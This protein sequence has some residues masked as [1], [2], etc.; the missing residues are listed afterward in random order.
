MA[1]KRVKRRRKAIAWG[2]T[3][4]LLVA[5]NLCVGLAISP[6]T[7]LDRVRV[8]G[9]PIADRGRI[10]RLL[11]DVA[12]VPVLRNQ[13]GLLEAKVQAGEEIQSAKFRQN[14]FGRGLLEI[15]HRVPVAVIAN[16]K[17]VLLGAEGRLYVGSSMP[18]GL[19]VLKLPEAELGPNLTIMGGPELRT[20]ATGCDF[21]RKNL[22]NPSWN[23][24]LD[25]RGMI[26][27]RTKAAGR[28]V[29]GSTDDLTPKLKR[30][31]TII[32]NQPQ[33]LDRVKELNLTAPGN[34]VLI[35][36]ST[37]NQP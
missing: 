36:L 34:P 24:E 37:S 16:R 13:A 14:V 6:A 7:G 8:E 2:P 12:A 1:R 30:L 15:V 32:E 29:L 10:E 9:A 17:S 31:Q 35:P 4:W 18:K 28:I 22:P 21:L 26:S 27:L 20:L 33:I 19:P 3:L 25:A 23:M 11:N 5:I